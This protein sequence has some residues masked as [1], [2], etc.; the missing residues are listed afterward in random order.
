MLPTDALSVD[1]SVGLMKSKD[2]GQCGGTAR[3]LAVVVII[4]HGCPILLGAARTTAGAGTGCIGSEPRLREVECVLHAIRHRRPV[5][6]VKYGRDVFVRELV[7]PLAEVDRRGEYI[8]PTRWLGLI[9]I[10]IRIATT[11]RDTHLLGG[12]EERVR[13]TEPRWP[14]FRMV[15]PVP[16]GQ[17][18]AK[19]LVARWRRH[20]TRICRLRLRASRRVKRTGVIGDRQLRSIPDIA[21]QWGADDAVL[22]YGRGLQ[23]DPFLNLV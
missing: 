10:I 5:R 6:N 8:G 1:Q 2:Y 12:E 11:V 22:E 3:I 15:L 20:V 13:R 23:S 17:R 19:H 14:G 18:A 4:Q 21:R 9:H 16:L 7:V